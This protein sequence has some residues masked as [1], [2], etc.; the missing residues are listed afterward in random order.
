MAF[1]EKEA[2]LKVTTFDQLG[3]CYGSVMDYSHVFHEDG[4]K[5]Q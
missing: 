1:V 5:I 2:R 4:E 3:N